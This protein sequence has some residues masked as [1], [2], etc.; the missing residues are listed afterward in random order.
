MYLVLDLAD[1]YPRDSLVA[2]ILDVIEQFLPALF[3]TYSRRVRVRQIVSNVKRFQC[4]EWKVLWET[5]VRFARK[6]TDNTTKRNQTSHRSN[7]SIQTRVV[8]TEHCVWRGGLSEA[9]QVM[10]SNLLPNSVPLN[11]DHLRSKHPEPAH[12]NRDPVSVSSILWTRPDS[13]Q[14]YWSSAVVTE[15]LDKWFSIPK[16]SQYFHTRSPVTMVDIDG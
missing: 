11:M 10:T 1:K 8:Y 5:V 2:H 6:E 16:M 14:E 9:N 7:Q 15:F 13:L 4:G 12:P 3:M